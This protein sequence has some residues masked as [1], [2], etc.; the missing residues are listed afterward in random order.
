MPS[1]TEELQSVKQAGRQL[2]HVWWKTCSK[3]D[4]TLLTQF[5]LLKWQSKKK[6]AV[7]NYFAASIASLMTHPAKLFQVVWRLTV[8]EVVDA[9]LEHL[10]TCCEQLAWHFKD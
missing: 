6:V 9:S 5:C 2:E 10:V 4:Q 8:L 3:A 1:F 7:K